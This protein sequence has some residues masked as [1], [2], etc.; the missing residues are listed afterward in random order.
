[1]QELGGDCRSPIAAYAE[2]EQDDVLR[3]RAVVGCR[4]GE[5]HLICAE[6]RAPLT[7]AQDALRDVVRSLQ[8]QHANELL[9][10]AEADNSSRG[11]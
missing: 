5:P 7:H 8:A 3:L 1:V 9:A 11:G 6:A 4:G 2:I 10:T